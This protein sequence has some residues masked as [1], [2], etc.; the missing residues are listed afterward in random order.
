MAKFHNMAVCRRFVDG[1]S[2]FCGIRKTVFMLCTVNE[3]VGDRRYFNYLHGKS[4]FSEIGA[5][6]HFLFLKPILSNLHPNFS[7]FQTSL[8]SVK[9]V[10][11]MFETPRWL[12]HNALTC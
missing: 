10:P 9:K 1:L 12:I 4:I 8:F 5:K 7:V 6:L 2:A 3:N 11:L